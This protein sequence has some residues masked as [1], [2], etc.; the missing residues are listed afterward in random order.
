MSDEQPTDFLQDADAGSN[1]FLSDP[2]CAFYRVW[3]M[4]HNLGNAIDELFWQITPDYTDEEIDRAV[5]RINSS[6][7]SLSR[8]DDVPF[9]IFAF[10]ERESPFAEEFRSEAEEKGLETK[11]RFDDE[12]GDEDQ[13]N[14]DWCDSLIFE[15]SHWHFEISR[16]LGYARLGEDEA[17]CKTWICGGF[18]KVRRPFGDD[19]QLR[20]VLRYC[21]IIISLTEGVRK[22]F[23]C[24]EDDPL[25]L[26]GPNRARFLYGL[27][28]ASR[29][30]TQAGTTLKTY[31]QK[32]AM[33]ALGDDGANYFLIYCQNFL[34]QRDEDG[35]RVDSFKGRTHRQEVEVPLFEM[36]WGYAEIN[37]DEIKHLRATLSKLL[38]GPVTV[39]APE[40]EMLK[41]GDI[42]RIRAFGT[43]RLVSI[44]KSRGIGYL[45]DLVQKPGRQLYILEITEKI[46]RE[47]AMAR[48]PS[49]DPAMDG[50]YIKAL[51]ERIDR[52]EC[53]LASAKHNGD[54]NA[55]YD[56]SD[57]LE[58]CRQILKKN[59]GLGGRSR[60]LA[61]ASREDKSIREAIRRAKMNLKKQGLEQ[62]ADHFTAQIVISKFTITYRGD[63]PKV[64]WEIH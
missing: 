60:E 12:D 63:D 11:V 43:T 40:F 59:T 16:E 9:D 24:D 25:V 41:I 14:V 21:S 54:V 47:A 35:Y 2:K 34:A 20:K 64:T 44:S 5:E 45:Y 6:D 29:L 53:N 15:L 46:S 52:Q 28:F 23:D 36:G 38:E 56:A 50:E 13:L 31:I 42:I 3:R 48:I 62:L 27:K 4:C 19:D 61:K 51:K 22:R 18:R 32:L 17:D 7:E 37:E 26:S 8:L 30:A 57:E 39:P 49:F 55:L 58:Q 33:N 10:R 1:S